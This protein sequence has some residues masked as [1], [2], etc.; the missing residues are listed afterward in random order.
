MDLYKQCCSLSISDIKSSLSAGERKR[1]VRAYN[2]VKKLIDPM[3]HCKGYLV[4]KQ[5]YPMLH[6]KGYLVKKQIDPLLHCKGYLVK[7]QIYPM[8]HCKAI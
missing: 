3:L 6:C 1:F 4:K 8:L 5:I 7:K 2:L